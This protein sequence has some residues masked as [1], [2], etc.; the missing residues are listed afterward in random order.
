MNARIHMIAKVQ[1]M[2]TT[3]IIALLNAAAPLTTPEA[4]II[5]EVVLQVLELRLPE[6]QFI[7]ICDKLCA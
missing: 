2:P 1:Q 5:M 4:D 6:A 3:E 7:G